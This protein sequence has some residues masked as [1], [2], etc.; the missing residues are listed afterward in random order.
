VK[1]DT[2]RMAL[3]RNAVEGARRADVKTTLYTSVIGTTG[4]QGTLFEPMYAINR[5]TEALLAASGMQWIAARNGLYM[6]LD[7]EHII[8][9]A[10]GPGVYRNPGGDGRAPY[11]TID[12]L[13]YGA[14]RLISGDQ[15]R[16][17]VY[18][19][20]GECA[21]QADLVALANQAFGFH[22]RYESES[23]E[24]CIAKFLQLMPERGEPVARM[25]TGCFQCIRNGAFEVPSEFEAATGRPCRSL[26]QMMDDCK[27]KRATA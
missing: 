18:N 1:M 13:A 10:A 8:R 22:V 14:A 4:A 3:H 6:E 24:A 5:Q 17:R 23:D 9:A 21:T 20:V 11:I 2:D 7:L 12:E 16:N 19:L 25:L 26:R 27:G 15:P